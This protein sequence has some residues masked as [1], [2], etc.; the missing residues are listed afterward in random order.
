[1]LNKPKLV[2]CVILIVTLLTM[3]SGCKRDNTGV[4]LNSLKSLYSNEANKFDFVSSHN[5]K[6]NKEYKSS[7]DLEKIILGILPENLNVDFG[8]TMF[9][10]LSELRISGY[11][12][13]THE[14][15]LLFKEWQFGVDMD[16]DIYINKEEGLYFKSEDGFNLI[17][18][19]YPALG[20][21]LTKDNWLK[22]GSKEE[23]SL[24]FTALQ[25]LRNPEEF[26]SILNNNLKQVKTEKK[27]DNTKIEAELNIFEIYKNL[28]NNYN[29]SELNLIKKLNNIIESINLTTT[30]TINKNNKLTDTTY[31]PSN[32]VAE[33]EFNKVVKSFGGI[34]YR[35]N[36]ESSNEKSLKPDGEYK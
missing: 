19:K 9:Y 17:K 26:D 29:T 24:I 11:A 18:N 27:D 5:I 15:A 28:F 8:L 14:T 2:L 34:I 20:D 3:F 31:L 36:Y 33:T 21:K 13:G 32:N 1:M 35:F 22:V 12:A 30:Y 23:A 4:L 25:K 10:N 6:I 16:F 7:T